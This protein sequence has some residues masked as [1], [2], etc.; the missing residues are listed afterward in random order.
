VKDKTMDNVQ[1]AL[2]ILVHHRDKPTDRINLF[3]S[4]VET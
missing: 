2:V 3:G 4:V 1:I